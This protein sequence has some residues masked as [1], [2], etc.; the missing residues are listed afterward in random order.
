MRCIWSSCFWLFPNQRYQLIE[1]SHIVRRVV[2]WFTWWVL[3]CLQWIIWVIL[4]IFHPTSNFSFRWNHISSDTLFFSCLWSP[5]LC[6]LVT[7]HYQFWS[8]FLLITDHRL[9]CLFIHDR[10][11]CLTHHRLHVYGCSYDPCPNNHPLELLY[12]SWDYSKFLSSFYFFIFSWL[13]CF[14]M[15]FLRINH[16][17]NLTDLTVVHWIISKQILRF[18]LVTISTYFP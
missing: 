16:P 1:F 5:T 12:S 17:I 8:P 9:H 18:T 13:C 11:H 15:I 4:V 10:L 3:G 2:H 6:P 7:T 14:T